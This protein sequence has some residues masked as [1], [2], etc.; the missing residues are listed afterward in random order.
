[1]A[2]IS[3]CCEVCE[4]NCFARNAKGD[5]PSRPLEA[6]TQHAHRLLGCT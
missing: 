5:P 4:C 3:S 6:D 2:V 1:M